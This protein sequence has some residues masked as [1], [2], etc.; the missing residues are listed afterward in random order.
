MNNP[1]EQTRREKQILEMRPVGHTMEELCEVLDG[2]SF[3]DTQ[4]I[5]DRGLLLMCKELNPASLLVLRKEFPYIPQ[6][7]IEPC[8]T[9][10]G[11]GLVEK[12][13]NSEAA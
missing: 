3:A 8:P 9:C 2:L 12:K 1:G 13:S 5:T 10:G 6:L 7:P 11:T 4:H